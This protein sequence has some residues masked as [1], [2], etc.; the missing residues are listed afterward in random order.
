M[1]TPDSPPS[2]LPPSVAPPSDAPPSDAPK[3]KTKKPGRWRRRAIWTLSGLIAL[4]IILR[5]TLPLALPAVLRK[6][7]GNFGMT[8]SYDRLELNLFS[9]DAGIWG[10]EFKPSEGGPAILAADYCHGNVSVLNLFR[11]RLNVWRV[12]ADGVDVNIDRTAD[13]HIPLLDRFVASTAARPASAPKPPAGEMNL[14]SPLRVDALRLD[15]IRVHIH[16]RGITP[17]I[18]TEMAMDLRLSDLGSTVHPAKFEMNLSVDP[19]LDTMRVTGEG[20]SAG[21]T[22]DATLDV[23]VRGIRLKPAAAYLAPLGIRPVSDGITLSAHGQVHTAPAPNNAEGFTASVAFDHLSA[24]ADRREAMALDSL[25]IETGVIDTKSIRIERCVLDGPRATADRAADGNLQLAG[26]EYDP[27]LVASKPPPPVQP[28]SPTPPWL[29]ELM[30]EKWSVGVLGVKNARLDFHDQGISPAVDLSLIVDELSA[31]SIDHDPANLNASVTL[32]GRVR[33]PGMIRGITL[34]GTVT[35]FADEKKFTVAVQA[36]GIKPDAVKPYLDRIGVESTLKAARFNAVATGALTIGD[37]ITASAKVTKFELADDLPLLSLADVTVSKVRINPATSAIEVGDIEVVG[38]GIS[39]LRDSA[40]Q[41]GALGFRTRPASVPS[42]AVVASK[43]GAAAKTPPFS[44]TALP[45]I[46]LEQF[47]WSGAKLELEDQSVSPATKITIDDIG[48]EATGLST[49]PNAKSAGKFQAWLASPQVAKRLTLDGDLKPVPDGIELQAVAAGSGLNTTPFASYLKPL[50]LEPKLTSGE[51]AGSVDITLR[52]SASGPGI[53]VDATKLRLS[54]GFS[55]LAWVDKVSLE[56]G[57]IDG[58]TITASQIKV[59]HPFASVMR[60][61]DGSLVAMGF[62]L[63]P[64]PE[65]DPVDRPP[66]VAAPASPVASVNAPAIPIALALPSVIVSGATIDWT[67]LAVLPNVRTEATAEVQIAD[68]TLGKDSRPADLHLHAKVSDLLNDLAIS[69]SFTL[70]P[71]R[72]AVDLDVLA[73]GLRA[74]PLAVYFPPGVQSSLKNG[75]FHTTLKATAARNPLGGFSAEIDAGPLDFRDDESTPAGGSNQSD[76]LELFHFDSARLAI[77][78]IDLPDTALAIDEVSLK[79]VRSHAEKLP[80]GEL[81]CAGLLIGGKTPPQKSAAPTQPSRVSVASVL[82]TTGPSAKELLAASRHLFPS[83]TV[84][85]LDLNVAKLEL[86]DRSRPK[87][88]PMIVSDLR[89]H[90]LDR[91]DW[92]GK[93]AQSKPP[94][95]LQFSCKLAPLVDQVLVDVSVTPFARQPHLNLDFAATGVHGDGLTRLVPELKDNIDGSGMSNGS[96]TAQLNLDAALD[97][98]SPLDFDVS[99]GFDLGVVLS[100]VEYRSQPDGPVLAGVDEVRSEGIRIVPGESIVHLK[101]LEITQPIG[102]ITRD[103]AGIHALGW[104]YKLPTETAA[105]AT[106]TASATPSTL[107]ATAVK[108]APNSPVAEV[109]SAKPTGEIRIDKLLISGLDFNVEDHAVTPPLIIPLNG[110]DVEVRN[111]SSLSPYED[112]PIRFSALVN[113]GK[114]KLPKRGSNPPVMEERDLFSQITANGEVSLYPKLHGWA[115]TSV[116]GLDLAE[117]QG[118]AA[119]FNETLTSGI[120]DSEVDLRFDPSGSIAINSHFT[121]TDLSLSEPPN[122]LIYRTLH[123]PAP[124]D[125]VIGVVEKEDKS[126]TLPIPLTLDPKHI[127]YLDVAAAGTAGIADILGSAVAAAPLKVAND[128]GG[129]VGLGGS[130]APQ[131]LTKTVGFSAGS[132]ACGPVQ[133]AALASLLEKLREDRS[134][135]VTLQSILGGEDLN[136]LRVR[137]NPTREESES[138]ESNLRSRK[139]ELLRLRSDAAGRARAD[140]ASLGAAQ[141]EPALDHLRA[142]DREIDA[143]D[144]S[145]DQVADL[146]KPG[147]ERLTERRTRAAA[148]QVGQDRLAAIRLAILDAGIERDRVKMITAQFNPS[149]Q[150]QGGEIKIVVV[151]KK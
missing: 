104:T 147:A 133:S 3:K 51:A 15:H 74:G 107:P 27:S 87:S 63:L 151:K 79:G 117:L 111:L 148:L 106:T 31:R 53:S 39:V 141:A 77:P 47:K 66:V 72:Q 128:L 97:R 14:S 68:L 76:N 140:L 6:I 35:P 138:L 38:P 19:L 12:E 100:K 92:L 9:G 49:D 132:A 26:I 41:L 145:L 23:L 113:S 20:Q 5:I 126:I 8:C 2:D 57:S 131:D 120:Y 123:L 64:V 119:Q 16:D 36:S 11:G 75:R 102:R 91:I 121:L 95:K 24:V 18:D 44:L 88:E 135:N 46:T 115:K 103:Q 13:G 96:L 98:R 42:T 90:N 118:A 129:L 21:K 54:D 137:A 149:A 114:V 67:D 52:M 37:T 59:V 122:G 143:T 94:T 1:T 99:R 33:A 61:E 48:V 40:G 142:I 56:N 17:E 82:P 70:G 71:A 80:G 93:D 130:A 50:G 86:T 30:K 127:S 136:V 101:T 109:S 22:L 58:N 139:A 32:I 73:T 4:G 105:T 146:L 85:V 150:L 34:D 89:L 45:K 108:A 116:S 10:L 78:R 110:L 60:N 43:P 62:R 25:A 7:A 125:V 29:V 83:V 81:A 84:G 112:K 28:P 134:L 69:G 65:V 144:Q 55:V 124:L